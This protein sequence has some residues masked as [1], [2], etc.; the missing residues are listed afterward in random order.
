M[1]SVLPLLC[2]AVPL[3]LLQSASA[4]TRELRS[5]DKC[6]LARHDH[7]D[8]ALEVRLSE[9]AS[10][11]A[12]ISCGPFPVD[13]WAIFASVFVSNDTGAKLHAVAYLALFDDERRLVACSQQSG[14][15]EPGARDEQMYNRIAFAPKDRTF[16]ATSYEIVIYESDRR[17]GEEPLS[18][19]AAVALPGRAG[20]VV[21]RLEATHA[22][23]L[24]R[25][26]FTELRQEA[27]VSFH[28]PS[29]KTRNSHLRFSAAADYDLYLD[30]GLQESLE[31]KDP[32][33]R[34]L[35]TVLRRWTA[36]G[37]FE[38]LPVSDP[39]L[40]VDR[41]I[42]LLDG[43]GRLVACAS[44]GLYW[45]IAPEDRLLSATKLCVAIYESGSVKAHRRTD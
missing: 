29:V 26:A 37:E 12:K 20:R 11:R 38:R 40:E 39:T 22:R 23:V 44:D 18:A 24:H 21:T 28:N 10:Y 31:V 3:S 41:H 2:A 16:N 33:G 9:R 19:E 34:N 36:D 6:D 14:E 15:F 35:R 27:A 5:G 13:K 17:P 7:R 8:R 4:D 45:L 1:R 25:D 32:G 43:D 30:T 42:A